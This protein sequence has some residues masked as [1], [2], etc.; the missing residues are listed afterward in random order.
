MNGKHTEVDG[1]KLWVTGRCIG[2]VGIMRARLA[3]SRL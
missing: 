2:L 3:L 1:D